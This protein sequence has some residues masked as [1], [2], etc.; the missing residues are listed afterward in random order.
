MFTISA[1]DH[2]R[3]AAIILF[4]VCQFADRRGAAVGPIACVRRTLVLAAARLAS[5]G[6]RSPEYSGGGHCERDDE[7]MFGDP[8]EHRSACGQGS[9]Q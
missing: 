4:T 6:R 2:A 5:L 9:Y 8:G 7:S 1:D 3:S